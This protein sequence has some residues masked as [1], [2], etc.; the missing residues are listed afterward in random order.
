MR[1]SRNIIYAIII[2]LAPSAIVSVF[3]TLFWSQIL[4]KGIFLLP[5]FFFILSILLG[6]IIFIQV[7]NKGVLTFIT[8]LYASPEIDDL[9]DS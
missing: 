6:I 4:S 2:G 1:E 5:F 8:W 9:S 3:I 7:R